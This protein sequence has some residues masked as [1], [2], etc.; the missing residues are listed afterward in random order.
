MNQKRRILFSLVIL[1]SV[2]LIWQTVYAAPALQGDSPFIFYFPIIHKSEPTTVPSPT[3]SPTPIPTTPP[4][5]PAYYTTSWYM[6]PS[7]VNTTYN[8]GCQAGNQTK[9]V[10]GAQDSL[11]ILDF[12]QPWSDGNQYGTLLLQEPGYDLAS[13]NDIIIYV[14]NFI[15]GYMACSDGVSTID[16][17]IGTSNFALYRDGVCTPL[18][19]FCTEERA[20]NHGKAWA[21]MVNTVN[22]WVIQQGYA[23]Q[24]T[25]S[26][27]NDIELSWNTAMITIAW[28]DGFNDA[29]N[30][31]TGMDKF[32]FYN[33]GACEGCPTR[34]SPNT[35]PDLVFDWTLFYVHYTAWRVSPAW[36][37]PE[38]YSTSGINARQWAYLSYWGVT[39]RG[40]PP[41]Y[42]LGEMT[43]WQA[44]S[45]DPYCVDTG[46]NNTPVQGWTQLF[47]EINYWPQ[48][49]QTSMPWMTDIDWP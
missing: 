3:P 15:S 23:S 48:T 37:I 39:N 22:N 46:T 35:N 18:S 47:N 31:A 21:A 30:D 2:G 38:I 17:G 4:G 16:V 8:K 32:V 29:N 49:S 5:P 33:Y 26:G 10:T 11:V 27:A 7:S 14:K 34:L 12:G 43:Q 25:V 20:Y 44:C 28:V 6:T 13:T 36:P 24:V 40:Y 45:G 19:W 42:Y 1:I 9:T 41:I